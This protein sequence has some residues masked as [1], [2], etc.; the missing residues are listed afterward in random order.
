MIN[1]NDN[2]SSSW[3]ILSPASKALVEMFAAAPV[4]ALT[5]F[6]EPPADLTR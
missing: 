1:A 2:H 4:W 3:N 6:Q 5:D